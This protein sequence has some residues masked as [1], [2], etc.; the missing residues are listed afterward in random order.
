MLKFDLGITIL[1]Q[2][3]LPCEN[4]ATY[5]SHLW[6]F[7]VFTICE[8][9]CLQYFRL[10]HD[11]EYELKITQNKWVILIPLQE[12]WKKIAIKPSVVSLYISGHSLRKKCPVCSNIWYDQTFLYIFLLSDLLSD[13]S[14]ELCC[15]MKTFL[16]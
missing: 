4:L 12:L 3:K 15:L 6:S 13:T 2:I 10:S 8:S 1:L 11:V 14:A 5:Y 16:L 7:A 9:W